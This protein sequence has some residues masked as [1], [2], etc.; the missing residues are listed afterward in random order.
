VSTHAFKHRVPLP[1]T[2]ATYVKLIN[3]WKMVPSVVDDLKGLWRAVH[4][5]LDLDIETAKGE[6]DDGDFQ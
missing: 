6:R 2:H 3:R 5:D 1:V 4:E